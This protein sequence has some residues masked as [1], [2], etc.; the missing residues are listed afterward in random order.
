MLYCEYFEAFLQ[1]CPVKKL[2]TTRL[3][4]T[5]IATRIAPR[6]RYNGSTRLWC[7]QRDDYRQHH[8]TVGPSGQSI[9]YNKPKVASMMIV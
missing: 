2:P 8:D 1:W 3:S 6:W 4:G 9:H 5:W 7:V